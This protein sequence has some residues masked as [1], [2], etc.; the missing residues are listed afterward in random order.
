M[1]QIKVGIIGQGRSGRNIH[2]FYLRLVPEMYKIVAIVD[3]LEERR[4]RAEVEF[5]CDTYLDYR[6][7]FERNDLDL[8]VNA[9]PSNLHVPVT[10]EFLERGFNVLCE[11]PLA[12]KAEEV[13]ELISISEKTG[14]LLAVFQ[15][16]RF[17]PTFQQAKK[18]IDSGILGRIINISFASNTF[19]RRWDWQV[20]QENY[21]GSLLNT[22]PHMLDQALNLFGYDVM[23]DITCFMDKANTFGDAED[24]VKLILKAPNRPIVEIEISCCST[25]PKDR[26][27]V[28]GTNGGLRIIGNKVEWK[29]FKP[30]EAPKQQL[31]REPLSKSDGTPTYCHEELKMYE[32]MWQV[33]ENKN[34]H[35]DGNTHAFYTSL[36]KTLTEK[37]PLAV[38]PEQIRLQIAIIEECH[39]K[40]PLPHKS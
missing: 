19:T 4:K 31:I 24:Y 33:P 39:R 18:I 28:Q 3:P 11:K 1:K 9:T 13:D 34:L 27:N 37:A 32:E 5:G 14:S 35:V 6:K 17:S 8:V 38:T 16:A 21:G 36:Y 29:Y 23:P 7:M 40:N 26:L 15:Q 20:L 12:R 10:K 22:G 30:E 2:G 25:Y